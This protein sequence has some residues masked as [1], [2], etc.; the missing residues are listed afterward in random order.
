MVEHQLPKL[1]V[2]GSSPVVRFRSTVGKEYDVGFPASY[3]ELSVVNAD[4]REHEASEEHLEDL[5]APPEAL[6]DVAGGATP[7]GDGATLSNVA[8]MRHEMLKAVANNLRA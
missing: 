3:E 8:N 4:E 7:G 1:R 2:A 5:E 6:A